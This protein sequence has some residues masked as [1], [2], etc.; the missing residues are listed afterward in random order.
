MNAYWRAQNN[1]RTQRMTPTV[2]HTTRIRYTSQGTYSYRRPLLAC[3][4]YD[5]GATHTHSPWHD[6]TDH[7][8]SLP[9]AQRK[10][11][12][13]NH[14]CPMKRSIVLYRWSHVSLCHRGFGSSLGSTTRTIWPWNNDVKGINNAVPCMYEYEY[15]YWPRT[16]TRTRSLLTTNGI[17][18]L[19]Y[20]T[21]LFCISLVV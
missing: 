14:H 13:I 5:N 12:E 21:E 16:R 9:P 18:L 20:G 8:C 15:E 7:T 3:T 11:F 6:T 1:T 17:R 19:P 4:G 2:S 10:N